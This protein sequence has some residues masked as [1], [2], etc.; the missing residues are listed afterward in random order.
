MAEE[1][2]L[3]SEIDPLTA[4]TP[5]LYPGC[6][7]LQSLDRTDGFVDQQFGLIW[8]YFFRT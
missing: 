1:W 7:T 8:L 2:E 3:W 4:P 6:G 5:C